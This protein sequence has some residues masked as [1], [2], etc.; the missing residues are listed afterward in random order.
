MA[1]PPDSLRPGRRRARRTRALVIG[2]ALCALL[3]GAVPFF[4]SAADAWCRPVP[5]APRHR[6][7]SPT[8]TT[9]TRPTTTTIV[10][11][12]VWTTRVAC[13]TRAR[14]PSPSPSSAAG[15]GP[16]LPTPPRSIPSCGRPPRRTKAHSASRA[17]TLP[18]TGLVAFRLVEQTLGGRLCRG[19]PFGRDLRN[20]QDHPRA[21]R[22][23]DHRPTKLTA[24]RRVSSGRATRSRVPT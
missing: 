11:N 18:G 23:E 7:T 20:R 16:G 17:T 5:M 1:T 2:V 13:S 21:H 19:F 24:W 22:A 4:E 10:T 8:T 9:T 3:A 14:S 15:A 12:P 6:A